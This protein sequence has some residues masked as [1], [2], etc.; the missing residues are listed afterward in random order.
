MTDSDADLAPYADD[1]AIIAQASHDAF[2]LYRQLSPHRNESYDNLVEE[3]IG[4]AESTTSAITT[5]LTK[6]LHLAAIVLTRVRLE[7]LIVF[8]YLVHE[9]P[10]D[11]FQ[12]YSRYAPI[13]EYRAMRGVVDDPFVAP[14]IPGPV[15][16]DALNQKALDAQFGIDPGFDITNSKYQPKWTKLNLYSMSQRRDKLAAT[17][18]WLYSKHIP[19][20]SLYVAF[21]RTGSSPVHADG[22]M[23]GPPFWGKVKGLDGV[24]RNAASFWSLLIPAYLAAYDSLQWYEALRWFGVACDTE[25]ASLTSRLIEDDRGA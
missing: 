19:L 13:E 18:G 21:Y 2:Q 20:A 23:L 5:L 12:P 16:P 24:E 11:G 4:I 1:L 17:A 22:S 9:R 6:K 15:D 7:Q 25:F 8:S 3:S 14:H 10:E